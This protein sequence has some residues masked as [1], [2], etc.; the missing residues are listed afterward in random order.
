MRDFSGSAR[1]TDQLSAVVPGG[2]HTYAKGAD[3]Y[4]E[5]MAP[6]IAWGQGAHVWDV[7]GNYYIE[8]GSGLRSVALGHA[9]P[10]V[11]EAVRR[12]IDLGTNFARPAAIELE[13]A[14]TLLGLL[15]RADMVKFAKNGSDVTAAL[16]VW[17]AR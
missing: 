17:P 6:V 10:R 3:Q 4:P 13:A 2:A 14:E 9:H 16:S 7:D 5:G 15:P 8:Y 11:N 1:L 12:A